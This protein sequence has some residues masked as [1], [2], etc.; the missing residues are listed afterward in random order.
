MAIVIIC[1]PI[2]LHVGG[3][4]LLSAPLYKGAQPRAG[5][6][7]F[8]WFSETAGGIGLAA[9]GIVEAA[10]DD[11]DIALTIHQTSPLR[12]FDKRMLAP[13]RDAPGSLD[14]LAAKLYRN[15]HNKIAQLDD[16]EA[17]LL[18]SYWKPSPT[19]RSKYAPLGEWLAKQDIAELVVSFK[20]IEALVG[21]LPASADRPQFWANT[22]QIYTNVQR[23][24]WRSAG[25]DAFLLNGQAMVRFLKRPAPNRTT[26][27]SP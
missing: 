26:T 10:S 24:A 4:S 13:E 12:A 3:R 5:D 7:V 18:L 21:P 6:A 17:K 8:I 19:Q 9:H 20:D 15:A 23:E 22:E 14:G 1:D 16:D 2:T 27:G 11:G 25:Y